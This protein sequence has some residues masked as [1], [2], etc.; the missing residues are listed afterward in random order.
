[1]MRILIADDYSMIRQY[2]KLILQ[3]EFQDSIIEEA[4]NAEHLLQKSKED[5]WDIIITDLSMPGMPVTEALKEIKKALPLLPVIVL[6]AHPEDEFEKKVIEAGASAFLS[7]ES[8][9]EEII[10]KMR[11]LLEQK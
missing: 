4:D 6:S 9:P 10:K 7:K 1:M 11:S 5:K 8:P 3:D 2:I